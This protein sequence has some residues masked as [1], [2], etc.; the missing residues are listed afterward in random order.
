MSSD[1]YLKGMMDGKLA[2]LVKANSSGMAEVA[3]GKLERAGCTVH[4]ITELEFHMLC[5]GA[6]EDWTK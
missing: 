5:T 1:I 2:A 4:I 3:T 6:A